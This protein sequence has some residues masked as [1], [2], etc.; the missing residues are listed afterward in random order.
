MLRLLRHVAKQEIRPGLP[1]QSG[2]QMRSK[3][4][5]AAATD[6]QQPS[7]SPPPPSLAAINK[8]SERLQWRQAGLPPMHRRWPPV[9]CGAFTCAK[10]SLSG[11]FCYRVADADLGVGKLRPG[12]HTHN[13][14]T[15][16]IESLTF[17]MSIRDGDVLR[18][19]PRQGV[20]PSSR[21]RCFSKYSIY[22]PILWR[23]RKRLEKTPSVNYLL[24]NS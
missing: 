15:A 11:L 7:L 9:Y 3:W 21:E 16:E 10:C 18:I 13:Q 2:E 14:S 24:A 22:L 5:A 4:E 23:R 8:L 19:V 12:L 6:G 20:A 1:R 17:R